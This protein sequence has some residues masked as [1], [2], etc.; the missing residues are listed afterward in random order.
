MS[1][2]ASNPLLRRIIWKRR[3]SWKKVETALIVY[4][5]EELH[6]KWERLQEELAN[7]KDHEVKLSAKLQAGEAKTE[8]HREHMHA[9]DESIASLQEVLL[10]SSKEL[11]KLEG[12]REVLK[13]RKK[14]MRLS[15][16]HSSR[17]PSR[18]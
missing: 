1:R 12:Q 2:F 8:E 7:N 10:L 6:T 18:I 9:I 4:E 5:I 14:R 3:K 15:T 16:A 13:E 11:E 17:K